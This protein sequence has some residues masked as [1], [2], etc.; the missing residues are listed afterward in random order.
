MIESFG[1]YYLMF[2]VIYYIIF[3]IIL[4]Y[5]I[6]KEEWFCKNRLPEWKGNIK[7]FCL[8][9]KEKHK[10]EKINDYVPEIDFNIERLDDII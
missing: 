8:N 2:F 9:C 3:I 5:N 1:F 7:R 10:Y 4:I 6:I